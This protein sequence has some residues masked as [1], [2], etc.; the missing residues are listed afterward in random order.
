MKDAIFA[1]RKDLTA[2]Q[3]LQTRA[4]FE[5]V[6]SG[7][8][9]A[10]TQHFVLHYLDF[11]PAPH[12]PSHAAAIFQAANA[13]IGVILPKRCARHAVTRNA[14]RRQIYALERQIT[15]VPPHTALVVRLRRS[16]DRK[17]FISATSGAFKRAVRLELVQLFNRAGFATPCVASACAP[18]VPLEMPGAL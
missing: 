2:V 14:I 10:K 17:I 12:C 8:V 5:A 4:Q 1:S 18:A 9:A 6:A 11:G 13:W 16:F 3:R 7:T 15:A